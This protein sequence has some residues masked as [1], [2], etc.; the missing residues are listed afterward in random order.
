VIRFLLAR[1]SQVLILAALDRTLD[2]KSNGR[3][4]LSEWAKPLSCGCQKT[5]ACI[6]L[7]IRTCMF[8]QN[9]A[10]QDTDTLLPIASFGRT[11]QAPPSHLTSLGLFRPKRNHSLPHF[12][13]HHDASPDASSPVK[14]RKVRKGTKNCWE[15]KRRKV[16]C[17]FSQPTSTACENCIRRKA[18]CIGQEYVAEPETLSNGPI[19]VETRLGRVESLLERLVTHSSEATVRQQLTSQISCQSR[20]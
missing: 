14:R 20:T 9:N 15:C 1:C 18:T 5:M 10:S 7:E 2:R 3:L 4:G 6:W 11:R 16:S 17:T 13:M 12:S 19:E 8:C